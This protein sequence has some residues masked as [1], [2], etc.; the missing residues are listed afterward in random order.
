[1]PSYPQIQSLKIRN[2]KGIAKPDLPL[3]DSLTL[4]TGVN[5]AGKTSAIEA[6]LGII[7]YFWS[8]WVRRIG[9]YGS[10]PR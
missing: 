1:M 5:G 7:T 10:A 6:L 9:G 3:D 4:L 8:K 2:F